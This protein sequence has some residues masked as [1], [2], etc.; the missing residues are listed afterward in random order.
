MILSK[1]NQRLSLPTRLSE[2]KGFP[3]PSVINIMFIIKNRMEIPQGK[4]NSRFL[5]FNFTLV[6]SDKEIL[7]T[8]QKKK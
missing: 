4:I 3:M 7:G 5:F 8:L 6:S 2:D 1:T